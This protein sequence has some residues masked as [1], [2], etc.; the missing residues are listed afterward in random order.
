VGEAGE[1]WRRYG[2]GFGVLGLLLEGVLD[3]ERER[4]L[5]NAFPEDGE[6][7]GRFLLVVVGL[8]AHDMHFCLVSCN[9]VLESGA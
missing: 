7:R 4:R 3:T 8:G 1:G 6:R 2:D 9:D 5:I